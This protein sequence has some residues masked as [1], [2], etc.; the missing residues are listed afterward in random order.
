MSLNHCFEPGTVVLRLGSGDKFDA[1]RELIRGAPVFTEISDL[2]AFE[3]AVI[4]REKSQSTGFGHGVAVA[5]GRVPELRRVLV[6]LGL[7]AA[8]IPFQSPDGEPVNLL[9][10]IASPPNMSLDYLQALSTLV[11]SLRDRSV[12]HSLLGARDETSLQATIR[13]IFTA[14]LERCSD[15]LRGCQPCA[16]TG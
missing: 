13:K 7:S 10:V 2:D 15:P 12:R 1:I 4:E 6:G 5:H 14:G 16:T 9:F 8:G 3:R 11:R